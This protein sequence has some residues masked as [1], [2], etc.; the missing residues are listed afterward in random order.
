MGWKY[1]TYRFHRLLVLYRFNDIA[2]SVVSDGQE[3][4]SWSIRSSSYTNVVIWFFNFNVRVHRYSISSYER[5][6]SKKTPP[7]RK[8][9]GIYTYLYSI[10]HTRAPVILGQVRNRS[11]HNSPIKK[12]KNA[13]AHRPNFPNGDRDSQRWSTPLTIRGRPFI[14]SYFRSPIHNEGQVTKR[15]NSSNRCPTFA[16]GFPCINNE[17]L[18]KR[19]GLQARF[20]LERELVAIFFK[21]IL[22]CYRWKKR[23]RMKNYLYADKRR[24]GA[25]CGWWRFD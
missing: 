3:Q 12:R 25:S 5:H 9:T 20:F 8:E 18:S 22:E 14:I 19:A 24:R 7:E 6:C 11:K 23:L 4:D 10:L 16:R 1:I 15:G 13:F 17:R 21:Y 2:L